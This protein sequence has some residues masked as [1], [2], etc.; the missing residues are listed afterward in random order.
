MRRLATKF[1]IGIGI[2]ASCLT[3]ITSVK[4][5]TL[6]HNEYPS[7]L[8]KVAS[9]NSIQKKDMLPPLYN[10]TNIPE[11]SAGYVM[12]EVVNPLR[13]ERKGKELYFNFYD[14]ADFEIKEVDARVRTIYSSSKVLQFC[15]SLFDLRKLMDDNSAKLMV[16]G[17]RLNHWINS[18]GGKD[19]SMLIANVDLSG[20]IDFRGKQYLCF[21]RGDLPLSK[22]KVLTKF[23][24]VGIEITPGAQYGNVLGK[25]ATQNQAET[26]FSDEQIDS[27]LTREFLKEPT[28]ECWQKLQGIKKEHR[29]S[30][31]STYSYREFLT[32]L[33]DINDCITQADT[34]LINYVQE[35]KTCILDVINCLDK[36]ETEYKTY[37]MH[38]IITDPQKL[39]DELYKKY[40]VYSKTEALYQLYKQDSTLAR[41]LENRYRSTF[42][43]NY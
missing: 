24:G 38:Y 33:N 10:A 4:E 6:Y 41:Q 21:L 9:L 23:I 40:D 5:I 34:L 30:N 42:T 36:A 18:T 7:V 13:I 27:F 29:P 22:D 16:G 14:G 35:L 8:T 37:Q 3:V 11:K 39:T 1:Q 43:S 15:A 26:Q 19:V 12:V 25:L 32:Q 2:A 17:I 20:V 28:L 31:F